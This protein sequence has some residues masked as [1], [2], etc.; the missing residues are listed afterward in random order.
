LR[1]GEVFAREQVTAPDKTA[2]LQAVSK[3]ATAMRARL[4]ESMASIQ[5][6]STPIPM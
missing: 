2:V 3:A 5:K 1:H 6:L 4:G